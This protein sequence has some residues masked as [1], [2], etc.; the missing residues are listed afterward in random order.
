MQQRMMMVV[1]PAMMGV[2]T[3]GLPAGVGI[4]WITSSMYQLFQQLV[5]NQRMG[6]RNLPDNW[7]WGENGK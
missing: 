3:I 7:K 1:M 2:M 5:M 4:F 6:I